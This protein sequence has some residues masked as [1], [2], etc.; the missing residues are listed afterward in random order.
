MVSYQQILAWSQNPDF[1]AQFPELPE[2]VF[3]E[4]HALM[5]K[6]AERPELSKR[7]RAWDR[8]HPRP[9]ARITPDRCD[10]FACMSAGVANLWYE[11]KHGPHAVREARLAACRD[12]SQRDPQAGCR[13]FKPCDKPGT[14]ILYVLYGRCPQFGEHH[15]P[16]TTRHQ[17]PSQP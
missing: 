15:V 8:A 6:I 9:D 7:L 3:T 5:A 10:V 17:S 16:A 11:E 13:R 14:W 1:R 12:C 2:S 4:P